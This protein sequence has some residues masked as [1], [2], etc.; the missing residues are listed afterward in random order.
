MILRGNSVTPQ[1][2]DNMKV[3]FSGGGTMGSVMPLLALKDDLQKEK[4]EFLW[5]GTKK[6]PEKD[7]VE[8]A[9]V[10]FKGIS[11]GKL[12]RYF[13]FKNFAIPFLMTCG[14]FQSFFAIL[15]FKPD[16]ILTAGGFVCVPVVHAGWIL[17]KKIIVHQQDLKVGLANKIMKAFATKVTVSFE[18]LKKYFSKKKVVVTGNPVRK[19]IFSG[20][21]DSAVQRFGIE[22][23]LPTLLIMGGGTGAL[24]INKLVRQI[25]A[26]LVEFCQVIHITGRG[27]SAFA[28]ASADRQP[29]Y[30]MF[31]FLHDEIADA[32]AAATLVVSRAGFGA[33]TELSALGK[34]TILIPLP[35]NDQLN[36]STYFASKEAVVVLNQANLTDEKFLSYIKK[37]LHDPNK[38]GL[39]SHNIKQMMPEDSNKKYI[40][41][42]NKII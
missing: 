41:L 19:M 5:I 15:K 13:T 23:N 6:G 29:R 4:A 14:F 40:D 30:H 10:E 18:E 34:P 2:S 7:V 21:K 27:K 24:A 22:P 1:H 28:K 20:S 39:L 38:L 37:V 33:L 11:A 35:N 42:I 25:L 12:R 36:N 8:K 31:E 9:G 17:R 16:I 26:N 3:L 32:Y